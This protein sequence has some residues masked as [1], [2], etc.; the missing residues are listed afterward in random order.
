M[1]LKLGIGCGL[2]LTSLLAVVAIRRSKTA[3]RLFA[4]LSSAALFLF[5]ILAGDA[6]TGTLL[7]GTVFM[8]EVHRV[9]LNP[10]FQ[11]S[12]VYVAI[13]AMALSILHAW[14]EK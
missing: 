4:W 13:Y 8:T 10:L 2:L 3:E 7:H 1:L 5:L 6:V 14:G 9:L 11:L 12:A